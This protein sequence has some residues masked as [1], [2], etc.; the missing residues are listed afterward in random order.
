MLNLTKTSTLNNFQKPEFEPTPIETIDETEEKPASELQ[1]DS[2]DGSEGYTVDC[3]GTTGVRINVNTSEM[4][5]KMAE[6]RENF[7]KSLPFSSIS[8][9]SDQKPRSFEA[10][11]KL[12]VRPK[13]EEE[14]QNKIREDERMEAVRIQ[15]K[16]EIF[17][18]NEKTTKIRIPKRIAQ[19]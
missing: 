11:L 9:E 1:Y 7:K 12:S 10:G 19:A 17:R 2:A 14:L 8:S 15:Q 13:T 6:K 3:T 5:R 18:L 4:K 16:D